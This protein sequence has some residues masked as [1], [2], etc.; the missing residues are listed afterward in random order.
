MKD[1]VNGTRGC[2]LENSK[3]EVG[4]SRCKRQVANEVREAALTFTQALKA[5]KEVGLSVNFVLGPYMPGMSP[6]GPSGHGSQ[7][8]VIQMGDISETVTTKY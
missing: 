4:V 5:A 6:Y 8:T 7:S 1:S 3:S 2:E